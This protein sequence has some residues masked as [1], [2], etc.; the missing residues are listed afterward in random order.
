[1]KDVLRKINGIQWSGS[2]EDAG[3][4]NDVNVK[5]IICELSEIALGKSSSF[6]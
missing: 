2:N 1:M 3:K 5:H 6:D 4:R